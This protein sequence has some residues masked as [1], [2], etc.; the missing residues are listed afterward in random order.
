M[1][2]RSLSAKVFGAIVVMFA[3][4][5]SA[6][7]GRGGSRQAPAGF[8]VLE[9]Y[10][11]S[12]SQ[13]AVIAR[14][15]GV[16]IASFSHTSFSI[17][18]RPLRMN[19]IYCANPEDAAKAQ[20]TIVATKKHPAFCLTSQRT[21]V[22]FIGDDTELAILAGFELGFRPRPQKASYKVWFRLAPTDKVDYTSWKTLSNLFASASVDRDNMAI[23]TR[24]AMLMNKFRF[25]NEVVLRS[26]GE[27]GAVPSYSFQPEAV[28]T[29]PLAGGDLSKY[30]FQDLPR[31][32][33]IPYVTLRATVHSAAAVVIPSTRKADEELLKA[34]E[35]WPCDDPEI[36]S[37]AAEI[38]DGCDSLEE[39]TDAILKWLKPGENIR[40]VES[41][42]SA[43]HGVKKVLSQKFGQAWDFSDCF[44][45]LA[46]ASKI[47][48]R[49]VAGWFFSQSAHVWAE[50][51]QEGSGWRQV[52][53]TGGGK[54]GC[55]IY[56]IP[57]TAS[58]DGAMSFMYLSRPRIDFLEN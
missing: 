10:E 43:R 39:K 12:A 5:P 49:Q 6:Q 38:T 52:E 23:K 24:I 37:L 11:I 22:E 46:R 58:E 55:G 36:I 25:G 54:T 27:A 47:P 57:L 45:T 51:L 26:L 44:I 19:V 18:G 7:G 8:Q 48:C 28:K 1:F 21:V 40:F 33:N 30:T 41:M 14:K 32:A 15:L 9:S 53:T 42:S 2:R 20:K 3:A 16:Q 31:D 13:R 35:H 4:L 29:T 50:V 56:H 34:T 17:H